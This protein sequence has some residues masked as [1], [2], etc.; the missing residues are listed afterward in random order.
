MSERVS[1]VLE[2]QER[3]E[4]SQG[5]RTDMAELCRKHGVARQTGYKW[6]QRYRAAGDDVRALDD[7]SR[8]PHTNPRAIAE[9]MEDLVVA[10]RKRF[11]RWGPV[12]LRGWLVE[13]HPHVAIPSA[14]A[15]ANVLRR[16]GLTASKRRRRSRGALAKIAPPFP[17]C[18]GPNDVWCIDFKGWF[19]TADGQ[20]CYPLTLLDGFSRFLLR[21]EALLEPNGR[22]VELALDSAFREFGLPKRIRSDGG[23]PFFAARSPHS[24]SRLGVWLLQLGIVLEC[25]APA[26]PQQNGRLERFHRTLKLEVQP[27]G[28][29]IEQQ[30]AFDR[31]RRLY[32]FERP[33]TAL[34]LTPPWTIYRRSSRKYPCALL[35]VEWCPGHVELV[36]RA[37]FLR[38]KRA[39]IFIGEAF[40]NQSL[41][42][43]PSA[44]RCWD[45]CFG[46]ILLGEIDETRDP[47]FRP[48]RRP[49]GPMRL[50]FRDGEEPQR[51]PR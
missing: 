20:R 51:V 46:E 6:L 26:K 25:I 48:L 16:R 10:A 9:E 49:R 17:E 2:W 42:V 18:D 28:S 41:R 32:N 27:A 39:R 5:R 38:L 1:F 50:S 31:F 7:R 11:P 15:I 3:W 13:K 34:G 24:L 37:G 21:C 4:A 12:L 19:R 22:E 40:A 30:R 23:P 14:R 33:H 43:L 36:D 8:R 29:V 47:P 45:V 44:G 35:R